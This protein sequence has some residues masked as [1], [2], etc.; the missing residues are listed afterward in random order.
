MTVAIRRKPAAKAPPKPSSNPLT[1]KWTASFGMPPFGKI[2]ARHFKPALEAAFREHNAE[3]EKIAANPARPTFANT[4][5]ALEKSGWQLSRVASVFW[6]LEASDSTPELQA[7]ARDMAPRFAAHETRILLDKRLFKRVNDLFERRDTLKLSDEDRRV[8]ERHHLEF[9]RAGAR[10]S[11]AEKSRVKEI[12][13][14]LATLVTQFMQNVLK[15]EQS[16]QLVLET[17]NDLAGLPPSLRDSAE[18]AARDAGVQGK[19]LVTLARSS[20]EGFLTFSSRRD[21]REQAFDAWIRRGAHD[22]ETD[23][24]Q[25]VAEAVALRS[26]YARL[27]GFK[28]FA[29]FSLQDTMA[30]TPEAV[31]DL[32][33]SVWRKAVKRA[34]EERDALLAEAQRSGDNSPILPWDWRYYAEKVRKAKFDFDESKL[35]P[36][37]ELD[38]MIRAAFDCATRLFGLKFKERND[39]PRYHPEVRIWEVLD[40]SGAHVGIF[41]GDYFARSSKR[42]GAWMSAFRS[43]HKLAKGQSPIIV[44]VLNFAKGADGAPALLSFDDARTL[45]HEFGHALHGLLSNVT[46]PS[47]SGTAVSRDFVELPSQLY[48]HWLSTREVLEK[49]AR[50]Y[51]SGKPMPKSLR[52]KLLA[53]RNFN[54]GFATVEYTSSAL[55]DMALYSANGNPIGDVERFERETLNEIG[56]PDEIVMRHR[57]PHFMHIM[58]GYAAGYYSYLWS[59]VMDADAFAAFEEAGDV[60]HKPTAKKLHEYIYSAGNRRD[61]H[62]A[63]VAFRGRP[64]KIDG[65]LKKRGLAA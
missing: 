6:N 37:L 48:E 52:D 1:S 22:G 62:A 63:Y 59:E 55:V 19:A 10:L 54:Q 65:L 9:V 7:V 40:R 42:S 31:G 51:K 25:I 3:I 27:M 23:N 39:L 57:L 28:S 64:P 50:H 49:H 4:I 15:D 44:N 20:V 45:F 41:M 61:P 29:E 60:F 21:L 47:I 38:N 17:E 12:N 30:K 16:W 24:R 43:Q 34:S 11:P 32:L 8:L 26:E 14:R 2:E 18:R 5:L 36:Y 33:H 58:S 56:M 46:Y 35:Q 13:A 53:A